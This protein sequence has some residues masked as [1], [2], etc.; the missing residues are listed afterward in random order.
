MKMYQLYND[1]Q[2]LSKK[3]IESPT[4][5]LIEM[6]YNDVSTILDR[7]YLTNI[8]RDLSVT[9]CLY[10]FKNDLDYEWL[11]V[12]IN[13]LLIANDYKYRKLKQTIDYTYDY[14]KNYNRTKKVTTTDSFGQQRTTT[15]NGASITSTQ[16]GE[17]TNTN[18]IKKA[19]YDTSASST[20]PFVNDTQETNLMSGGTSTITTDSKTDT[21]N[22]DAYEDTHVTQETEYGDLSVRTVAEMIEKEREIAYFSLYDTLYRDIMNEIGMYIFE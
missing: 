10:D 20:N 15:I 8:Y 9:P 16:D 5:V 7:R 12:I 11:Q 2:K 3:L 4:Q 1:M 13:G 22:A 17:R 6:G 21:A 19:G 18:T 14:D